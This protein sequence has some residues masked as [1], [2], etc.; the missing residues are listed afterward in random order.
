METEEFMNERFLLF[1]D[2]FTDENGKTY[3]ERRSGRR[4]KKGGTNGIN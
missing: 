3:Y 2:E 1:F 4:F